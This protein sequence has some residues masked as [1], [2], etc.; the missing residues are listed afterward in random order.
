MKI[1]FYSILFVGPLTNEFPIERCESSS[2]NTLVIEDSCYTRITV[3][4]R[5]LDRATLTCTDYYN[6]ALY[7]LDNTTVNAEIRDEF[8]NGVGDDLRIVDPEEYIRF[9]PQDGNLNLY[10]TYEQTNYPKDSD[11]PECVR[12]NS[13]GTMFSS[14]S[15]SNCPPNNHNYICKRG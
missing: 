4:E 3:D 8:G 1:V 6:G 2:A 5:N 14:S 11:K 15:S 12:I 9:T 13:D 10:V 7:T